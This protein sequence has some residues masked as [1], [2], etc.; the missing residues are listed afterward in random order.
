MRTRLIH[1][2]FAMWLLGGCGGRTDLPSND[3]SDPHDGAGVTCEAAGVRLCG[4][5]CPSLEPPECP[6][7]GCTPALDRTT[8][9]PTAGGV[10]WYDL[11]EHTTRACAACED[12]EA[13]AYRGPEDLV[14]V[15]RAVCS[16]LWA[17]GDTKACRYAD[18]SA[19]T[20][21]ATP[22]PDFCPPGGDG[23]VCGGTCACKEH[24]IGRSPLHPFGICT[25]G[26]PDYV[27]TCGLLPDH[28]Y[29][30]SCDDRV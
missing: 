3:A 9:D 30:H 6:G 10:C 20:N 16:A 24:C 7:Y 18:K 8:L 29:A 11:P 13:C 25:W 5:A 1:A 28:T 12:G 15:P 2:A 23:L 17:L 4:G 19:Y 26:G 14:C 22:V 27:R 21:D